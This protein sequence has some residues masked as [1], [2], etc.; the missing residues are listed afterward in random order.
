MAIETPVVAKLGRGTF[1]SN[2]NKKYKYE[3]LIKYH[4]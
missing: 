4:V 2:Y 3:F 1:S